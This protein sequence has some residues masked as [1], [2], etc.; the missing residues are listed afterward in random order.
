M[1]AMG[2]RRRGGVTILL[3]VGVITILIT[4]GVLCDVGRMTVARHRDQIIADAAAMAA[5]LELPRQEQS[6]AAADRIFAYYHATYNPSFAT[7]L[8]FSVDVNNL[9]VSVRAQVSESVPMIFPGLMGVAT[10]ATQAAAGASR[11][12][13]A[14][15]L[16]GLVPIGIQYDTTFDLPAGGS[17]SPNVTTLKSG[18]GSENA[19]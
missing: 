18:S 8:T 13:P 11:T 14:A 7:S 3:V 2:R 4:L 5:V 10:R 6:T 15:L 17:A 19:Q 9:P 12:V 16:Q 1:R